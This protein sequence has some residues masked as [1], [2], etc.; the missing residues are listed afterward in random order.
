MK[1]LF[2]IT[3]FSF[4]FLCFGQKEDFVW[5]IG[6]EPYD[7]TLPERAADTTLGATNFDF[8]HDPV[9]VYYDP[10]RLWDTGG[11]NTSLCSPYGQLI[12][13]SNGQI[14]IDGK[15]LPSK[16]Q[17]IMIMTSQVNFVMSGK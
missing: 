4:H 15:I 2:T 13:Y 14:I 11:G 9:K 5:L 8:N 12:A 3:F 7:V 10:Q 6:E 17:S 16:T 1:Y